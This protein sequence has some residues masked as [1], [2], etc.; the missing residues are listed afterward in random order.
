MSKE[1]LKVK[2]DKDLFARMYM[3]TSDPLFKD[4]SNTMNN[5]DVD[6]NDAMSIGQLKSK[7]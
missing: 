3:L 7:Q 6:F 4:I 5:M 1:Q 2:D